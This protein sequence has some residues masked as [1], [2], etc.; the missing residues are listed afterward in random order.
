M[1]VTRDT[2][3]KAVAPVAV[4]FVTHHPQGMVKSA[5]CSTCPRSRV[6]GTTKRFLSVDRWLSI[7]IRGG[8]GH[9]FKIDKAGQLLADL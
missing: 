8:T 9:L 5:T 6:E 2:E 1:A 3:W 4:R 7:V